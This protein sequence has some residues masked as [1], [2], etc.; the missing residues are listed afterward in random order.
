MKGLKR[1]V[2]RS[3]TAAMVRR[4]QRTGGR[5][6]GS[7][8]GLP[9]LLLTIAGRRTGVSHTVPVCYIELDDAL[10]IAG[11]AGGAKQEPQW[12]KNLRVAAGANVQ[13]G[14]EHFAVEVSIPGGGERAALWDHVLDRAP[15][16][17]DYERKAGRTI[18]LALLRPVPAI[19]PSRE[20]TRSGQP[21]C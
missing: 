9:I 13:R 11:S 1:S 19:I 18:P 21:Q 10:L 15:F 12:F 17:A 5:K 14:D 16:F 7:A 2:L 3:I 8:R 4:Y 20:E 6:S